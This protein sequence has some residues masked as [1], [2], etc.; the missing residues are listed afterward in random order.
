MS[1]V[2]QSKQRVL[3]VVMI[4]CGALTATLVWKITHQVPS[5]S[6]EHAKTLGFT[7]DM[8]RKRAHS[9]FA[10]AYDKKSFGS[11][12][13]NEAREL[14]LH[15]S[16]SSK[17]ILIE[18][19]GHLHG[20]D[21]H[22]LALN[23]LFQAGVNGDSRDFWLNTLNNWVRDGDKESIETCRSSDNSDIAKLGKEAKYAQ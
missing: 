15:G 14:I 23:I 20:K 8:D 13:F 22:K 12:E 10:T 9:L 17:E 18:A 2:S 3:V 16:K 19:L 5:M 21:Q 11:S 1:A 4:A 6:D 7:D